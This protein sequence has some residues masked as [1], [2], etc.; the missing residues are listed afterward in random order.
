M[1]PYP[2]LTSFL[3]RVSHTTRLSAI[4][5]SLSRQVTVETERKNIVV[6]GRFEAGHTLDQDIQSICNGAKDCELSFTL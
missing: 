2:L 6:N 3:V 4:R 5:H 1:P